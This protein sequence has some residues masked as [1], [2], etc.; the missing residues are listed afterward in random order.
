M[1]KKIGEKKDSAHPDNDQPRFKE[2]SLCL[3]LH[4]L[5]SSAISSD[6]T[7]WEWKTKEKESSVRI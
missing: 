3:I 2:F 4:L 7:A 5:C 1:K 6:L